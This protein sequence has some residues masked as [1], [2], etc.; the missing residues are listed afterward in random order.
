[1]PISPRHRR[2]PFLAL[3]TFMPVALAVSLALGGC[4]GFSP[5]GGLGEVQKTASARLGRSVSLA[6]GPDAQA[7]RTALLAQPLSADAAVDIALQ[8]NRAL[9]ASLAELGIAEADYVQASRLPNPGFSFGRLTRG[10]ALE[11]DRS[12]QFDLLRLLLLPLTQEAESS[13]FAQARAEAAGQVIALASNTRRAWVEAVAAEQSV[14]YRRQVLESAEAGA[15]LARRMVTAGNWSRQSE[16]RELGFHSDAVL[17]LARAEQAR[18]AARERLTRLL[19]LGGSATDAPTFTLP[20]RLPALPAAPIDAAE[21]VRRA[22]TE[23]LDVAAARVNA[24][25]TARLFGL[26][27]ATRF[28][29]VLE[30]GGVRNSYNDGPTE[31]GYTIRLELPLFDGGQT[32]VRRAEAVYAQALSRAAEAAINAQS[33]LREAHAAY[34]SRFEVARHH[35]IEVVPRAKRVADDNLLRYNGMLIG[36]F[37]LL[38]SARA[39]I[40][41]VDAALDAQRQ[42]WLA[43]AALDAAL[44]GAAPSNVSRELQ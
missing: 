2:T 42:F 24:E 13:R 34:V 16:A 20:D 4:A 14:G 35:E 37:D 33:D 29:D 31:R 17:G 6:D 15:D 12:L 22:A 39:Q 30:V 9:R 7:R 36:V 19:G 21:V 43:D 41:A 11:I 38:A 1:M 40:G 5:D 32:R 18:V 8:S 10:G 23:R 44:I 26:T 3:P 28:V 25:Q 27:K